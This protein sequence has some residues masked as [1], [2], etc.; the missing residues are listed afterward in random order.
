MSIEEW[1]AQIDEIDSEL[2]RL[3]NCR[4]GLAAR[5]GA[6]KRSAKLPV[7][8]AARERDVLARLRRDNNGPLDESAVVEI[9]RR[10][11]SETR[12]VEAQTETHDAHVRERAHCD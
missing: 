12:R 5:I 8:D 4:A 3:L 6:L 9:F 11:I 10:I 1:R 2:L 7:Y